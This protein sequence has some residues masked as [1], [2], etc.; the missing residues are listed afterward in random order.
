MR[1]RPKLIV[2]LFLSLFV[3]PLAARAALFAFEDR[4]GSWSMADW[5]SVGMLPRA[6]DHPEPRVLVLSGRTGGLKGVIAVHSWLVVKPE[7]ARSWTRYDVVGWGSPVRRNG[8]APD[9]R[10]FGDP[11]V[12]VADVRGAEAAVLIP[13]IEAAVQDYRFRQAGDYRLWPGP[14]SNTFVATV[15]RAVPELRAALPPNAIGKD[16]REAPVYAGLT[17]SRTG[18]E[19]GA[20]GAFGVKLGWI[21]GLEIN[22]LGLVVGVDFR[23][24]ALKLPGF[25]RLGMGLPIAVAAPGT[26][27]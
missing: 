25:G 19:F 20:F 15:L 17:D 7:K 22:L 4:P 21:E 6:S 23:L 9:A 2:L 14:N 16:W 5:S 24:P 8:W 1:A 3:L 12:I 27:S 10:W 13:K 11:P 18:I 26:N